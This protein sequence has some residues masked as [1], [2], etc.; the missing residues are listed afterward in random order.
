M[1]PKW[2]TSGSTHD[3]PSVSR[4]DGNHCARAL[5]TAIHYGAQSVAAFLQLRTDVVRTM[6]SFRQRVT[7]GPL[8]F[9]TAMMCF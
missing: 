3:R 8:K 6:L 4:E 1:I 7:G 9:V 5:E 2:L